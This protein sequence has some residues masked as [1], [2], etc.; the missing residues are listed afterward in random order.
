MIPK[1]NITPSGLHR[2]RY[3]THT[4]R[5]D[6]HDPRAELSYEIKPRTRIAGYTDS[7]SAMEQAVFKILRT[8][9]YKHVI[10]DWSYGIELDDLYGK[11]K[12]YAKAQIPR[13]ITDALLADDRINA[14]DNFV[15]NETQSADRRTTVIVSF[16]VHTI[17]GSFTSKLDV[18]L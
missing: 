2:I 15:F 18:L 14:V 9:R 4:F 6:L 3:P 11:P 16:T 8:D 17:H 7:L 13:R 1:N 10:Y 12:P 5:M